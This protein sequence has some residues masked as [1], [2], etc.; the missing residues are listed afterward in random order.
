MSF[1]FGRNVRMTVFG[2]SHAPCVGVT[3]DGLPAGMPVDMEE[4]RAFL[5]RRAPSDA[6]GST[7]RREADIPR[8]LCGLIDGKTCG[9][10]LTLCVDNTDARPEDYSPYADTPRPSHADYTAYV[11]YGGHADL[12]GGGALSGRMTAAL[13]MAGGV[14][15]QYIAKKG[16]AINAQIEHIAGKTGED[17]QRA[18]QGARDNG[19]SV[20]GVIVC[21]A[22]G[23]PAGLGE[24]MMDSVEGVLSH[25]LF[26]IPGVR[27][28][29]FGAGFDA[30]YMR[31]S[32]HN[33]AF[34]ME[35]GVVRTS[36]N[37]HGG[38]LGGIT[39]GM[40]LS[41]RVAVKPTP[42]IALAQRTVNLTTGENV[43]IKI[44]GRHDACIVPRALPCVESA[45]AF[46]LT[47]FMLG[48]A[49]YDA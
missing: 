40:P 29:S 16:V 23:V 39:S 7:S 43:D 36:T 20:G 49:C 12:R 8:V 48:G 3:L 13:C 19:D 35:N 32:E 28:V 15:M 37:H 17:A 10:P 18:I 30:A 25:L 42:S 46:V 41:F 27:G 22:Q 47:D 33:D 38:V 24:P 34:I 1:S 14:C 2:Q 6:P 5:S 26:A 11:K 31:G 4:L 44:K 21:T 45:A 9:A